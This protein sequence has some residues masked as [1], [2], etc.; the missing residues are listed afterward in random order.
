MPSYRAFSWRQ[1]LGPTGLTEAEAAP[2]KAVSAKA[3]SAKPLQSGCPSGWCGASVVSAAMSVSKG[4][5]LAS[6]E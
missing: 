6:G 5:A 4:I 2:A 3:V 1:T